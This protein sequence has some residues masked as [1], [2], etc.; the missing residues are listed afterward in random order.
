MGSGLYVLWGQAYTLYVYSH[1]NSSGKTQFI[2]V[3]S[4]LRHH[5]AGSLV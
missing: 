1:N 2:I 5:P 3:A 4:K